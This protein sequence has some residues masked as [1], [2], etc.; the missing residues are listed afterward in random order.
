[1]S[2]IGVTLI[3][4]IML[5]LGNSA[6]RYLALGDSYTIGES[7]GMADRWPVRLAGLLR[8]RGVAVA[9]P[10]I[11]ARTGWTVR[12]LSQG[13][14]A[15][16]PHGPYGLVTLLIGVNDQ[17]RGGGP[18]AY[19]ADFV[20]MLRRAVGFAGGH[21]ERVVVLSI[22]DWSVTPFAA[23]SG[24]D[25]GKIAA[26][27]DRFNAINR[28]ETARAGARYVDVTPVSRKAA[29]EGSLIAADGLHPSGAMYAE[30]V[31][32]ALP[33]AEAALGTAARSAPARPRSVRR[34]SIP[35]PCRSLRSLRECRGSLD[36]C[37]RERRWRSTITD[38][39]GFFRIL[40][41]S[42]ICCAASSGK[43]GFAVSTSLR[44]NG[45][46]GATSLPSCA[47]ARATSSGGFAG[48]G[49]A[50]FTSTC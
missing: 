50:G 46:P 20:A 32:L 11:V 21:A 36:T 37:Q 28:E 13:I 38:T 19:R 44:W 47:A 31:R 18:E 27:I 5:V 42:R 3:A 9:D 8:E 43:T 49:T 16:A 22:P 34:R 7:V 25:R 10:E 4:G 17:Y 48:E 2:S 45:S 40:R 12:E 33:A 6:P 15:V 30:W 24:R 35:G 29:T 14:D 39:S 41:W 26:E 23:E 1:M